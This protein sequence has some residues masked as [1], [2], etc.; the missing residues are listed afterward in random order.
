MGGVEG[1]RKLA[2]SFYGRVDSEP[3]LRPFF[4]GKTHNCAIEEM[5]AFL[6]QLLGGPSNAAQRRWW[7]SLRESH[8]RF[9]IET[10]HRQAWMRLMVE[11]L[12][13]VGL[14]ESV[15]GELRRFFEE[16]SAYIIGETDELS[17]QWK[18]QQKLDEAVASIRRGETPALDLFRPSVTAGLLAEMIRS[19]KPK[20]RQDARD[21]ITGNP[22]LVHERYAGWTLLH[23]AAAVGDAATVESLLRA[24]ADPKALDGGKHTPLYS[25]GNGIG[26]PESERIVRLLVDAGADVDAC[27]G[28]KRCTPL[29]MAARRGNVEIAKALLACGAN[30]KARDTKGETPLKRAV[31]CK[32][33]LVAELLATAG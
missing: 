33:R 11:T 16:A 25:L 21:H 6:V 18:V 13:D 19:G 22:S 9:K 28:V 31:N 12:D 17:D 7:L 23:V 29:H 4:P 8:A 3:L 27:E 32:K 1:C 14:E 30:P 10:G 24:G 2:A 5:S 26:V 15:R 20:L